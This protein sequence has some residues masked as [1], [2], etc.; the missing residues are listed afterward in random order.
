MK[1]K[2][3]LHI[4]CAPCLIMPYSHLKEKFE[5]TGFW[6]NHNIHPVTEYYARQKSVKDLC[7]S[8]GIELIKHGKYGLRDFIKKAVFAENRRCFI[9]YYDRLDITAE[10]AKAHHFDCFSTTLLYSKRQKHDLLPEIGLALANKHGIDFYY[11]DF[12][13]YWAE[14]REISLQ[15]NYYRQKYCG[16][17]FSEME[18]YLGKEP[19]NM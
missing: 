5:I 3:L 18:R 17:I 15:Q 19:E 6:F 16:C 14:G 1:K 4:C 2:M 10:Y 13:V 11:E 7:K 9:C 12:R 8:E